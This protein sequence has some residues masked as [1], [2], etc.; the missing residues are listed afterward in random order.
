[1]RELN[2]SMYDVLQTLPYITLII[3]IFMVAVAVWRVW[4][5]ENVIDRLIAVDLSSTLFLAVT[6]I[7]AIISGDS[8]YIDVALVLAAMGFISTVALSKYI[9]TEKMF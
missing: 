6:V 1:M 7:I 5:G 3:H 4:R 8:I 9:T 2:M